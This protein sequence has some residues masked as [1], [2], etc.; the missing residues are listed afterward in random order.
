MKLAVMC[1]TTTHRMSPPARGRGLKRQD[2]YA[3]NQRR[4]VAPRAGA[5]I[6]T[7]Q[8]LQSLTVQRGRPPRG[9]VD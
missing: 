2:F 5:W 7:V 8:R 3:Q 1:A 9:G 4:E 6:E